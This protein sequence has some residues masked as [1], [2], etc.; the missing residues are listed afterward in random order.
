MVPQLNASVASKCMSVHVLVLCISNPSIYF[1]ANGFRLP[2]PLHASVHWH[3]SAPPFG[4]QVLGACTDYHWELMNAHPLAADKA[5]ET[6]EEWIRLL[7]M[8]LGVTI[9]HSVSLHA[10]LVNRMKQLHRQFK[11]YKGGR[12]KGCIWRRLGTLR[13]ES[14]RLY[15]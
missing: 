4:A 6:I 9:S 1:H 8:K 5:T 14:C 10:T 11:Q 3:V 13:S 7:S 15:E 2:A 12:Q